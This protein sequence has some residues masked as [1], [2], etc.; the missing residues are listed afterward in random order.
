MIQVPLKNNGS[1]IFEYY[2]ISQQ[3]KS[4]YTDLGYKV[5]YLLFF[6]YI[7]FDTEEEAALFRLTYQ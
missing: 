3:N 1:D 2:D 4:K 7:E 6:Q 5:E